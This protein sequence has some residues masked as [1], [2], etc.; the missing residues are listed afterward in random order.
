MQDLRRVND[1][2]GKGAVAITRITDARRALLWSSTLKLQT[3]AQW[4]LK[5]S[6]GRKFQDSW[7]GSMTSVDGLLGEEL[8]DAGVKINQISARL[9]GVGEKIQYTA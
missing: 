9:Q 6:S 3:T 5:R 1:F 4:I 8:Q 2:F 7:N